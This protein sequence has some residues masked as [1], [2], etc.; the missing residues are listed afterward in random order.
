MFDDFRN[1]LMTSEPVQDF[2]GSSEP[3]TKT[4]EKFPSSVDNRATCV[5]GEIL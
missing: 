2:P 1:T 4:S 5:K 3:V